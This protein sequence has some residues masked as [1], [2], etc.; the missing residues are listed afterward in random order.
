MDRNKIVEIKIESATKGHET[1]KL[2]VCEA[3]EKI[4]E[5]VEQH[6][7][8]LYVDGEF[9]TISVATEDGKEKLMATLS[10]ARD[11][12]LAGQLQGG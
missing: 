9:T 3:V 10:M 5:E 8:W 1:L 11:I 12:T 7:K 4:G 6:G 2:P